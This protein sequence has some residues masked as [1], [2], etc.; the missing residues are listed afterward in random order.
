[1]NTHRYLEARLEDNSMF[2]QLYDRISK[3]TVV[4]KLLTY[5]NITVYMALRSPYMQQIRKSNLLVDL[6][7][8]VA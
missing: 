2:R 5:L 8:Y 6:F 3:R 4:H 7:T 1:M